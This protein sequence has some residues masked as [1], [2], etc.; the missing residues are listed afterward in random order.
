MFVGSM[1]VCFV[2]KPHSF[3]DIT[4]S[5]NQSAVA[6]SL[7]VFPHALVSR[8][9]GPDLY[10]VT[11]LF[12]VAAFACENRSVWKI[13]SIVA[14]GCHSVYVRSTILATLRYGV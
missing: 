9:V 7:I 6:V 10:A 14:V 4:I 11:M 2:V 3:V 13:N 8:T 1:T 12:A 5:V